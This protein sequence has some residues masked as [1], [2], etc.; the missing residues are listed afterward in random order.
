MELEHVLIKI[1]QTSKSIITMLFV[2][3]KSIAYDPQRKIALL[4]SDGSRLS[5]EATEVCPNS[6]SPAYGAP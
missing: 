6:H 1:Q 4:I 2:R 3:Q 5:S